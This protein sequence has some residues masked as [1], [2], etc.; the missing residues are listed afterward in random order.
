MVGF[1]FGSTHPTDSLHMVPRTASAVLPLLPVIPGRCQRVRPFGRPDDKLRGEPG[2]QELVAPP[3][4]IFGSRK[5]A[6]R[7]DSC[8]TTRLTF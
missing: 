6:P 1:A 4:W 8:D 5:S 2:I 3:I 7:N